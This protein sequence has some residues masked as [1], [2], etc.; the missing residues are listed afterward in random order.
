MQED[1][2]FAGEEN[3]SPVRPQPVLAG[4]IAGIRME[5]ARERRSNSFE[6]D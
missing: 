4:C 3:L 1:T 2:G 5:M 6:E